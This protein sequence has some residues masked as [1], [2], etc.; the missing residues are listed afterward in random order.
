MYTKTNL[1]VTKGVV[2]L[3][4]AGFADYGRVARYAEDC[5]VHPY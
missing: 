4:L 1:L 3:V 2:A 5:L